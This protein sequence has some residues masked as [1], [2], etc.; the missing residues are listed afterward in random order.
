M[1]ESAFDFFIGN[2]YQK[3]RTYKHMTKIKKIYILTIY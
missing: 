1:H 2:V 3:N